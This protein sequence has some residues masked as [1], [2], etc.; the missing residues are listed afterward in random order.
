[1]TSR[2]GTAAADD[3]VLVHIG[4]FERF[5]VRLGGEPVPDAAWSRRSAAA[6]VKLLA[7]APGRRLHRERIID[8]LWPDT[9]IHV[10]APRLHKAAHYA[11]RGLGTRRALVLLDDMVTLL[12][13]AEVVVDVLGFCAAAEDALRNGSG[14]Q[15]RA[16]LARHGGEL[17][18]EDRYEPWADGIRRRVSGLHDELLARLSPDAVG[19]AVGPPRRASRGGASRLVGRRAAGD[20]LR[21]RIARTEEAD[22]GTLIVSGPA[23]VGKS[24]MLHAAAGLASRRG[25]RVGRG[26]ASA[27]EAPWAYAPVLEAVR[28]LC[29]PDGS[30]LP[31][32]RRAA[33]DPHAGAPALGGDLRSLLRRDGLVDDEATRAWLFPAVERLLLECA[34]RAPVLLVIDDV[35]D[36]DLPS[37]RLLHYLARRAADQRVLL[38]VT[39]RSP[40]T[41]SCAQLRDSLLSRDLADSLAIAPLSPAATGRLVTDRFP[42]LGA[43][44]VA[45]VVAASAGLPFAALQL[46]RFLSGDRMAVPSARLPDEVLRSL[47]RAA[48]LGE[49][50]GAAQLGT[51]AGIPTVDA[52]RHLAVGEAVSILGRTAAGHRFRHPLLRE[53]LATLPVSLDEPSGPPEGGSTSPPRARRAAGRQVCR[54]RPTVSR[55]SLQH[56]PAAA[57]LR[58]PVAAGV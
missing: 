53:V 9:P 57:V 12:P 43:D 36:A 54:L 8:A 29:G 58:G 4:L 42:G 34:E 2:P 46:G 50:F 47:Q 5:T 28:H 37:V 25:W 1:V 45:E 32:G 55:T 15:V 6:L 56:G 16:A 39:H 33:G 10:A 40:T 48:G 51:R 14:A 3:P 35:D 17:L 41:A 26:A 13:D 49:S 22:G 20:V 7:L 38:V 44:R 52:A 24:A 18:P 23:G 31:G 21:A 30:P 19:P 11:R 27:L